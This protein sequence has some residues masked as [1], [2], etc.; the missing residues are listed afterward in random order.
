MYWPCSIRWAARAPI[1]CYLDHEWKR[2]V[3]ENNLF[4]GD[5]IKLE[6]QKDEDNLIIVMKI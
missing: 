1:E 6:V 5:S 2:F 4:V 3:I